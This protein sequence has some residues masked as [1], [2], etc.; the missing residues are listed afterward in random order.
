MTHLMRMLRVVKW[1]SGIPFW[2]VMMSALT[3]TYSISFM[4]LMSRT[5][6]LSNSCGNRNTAN[7]DGEA[8][9]RESQRN[10]TQLRL[11]I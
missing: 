1:S 6:T 2:L 11:L 7:R 8:A 5:V 4:L 10:W 9:E 3:F